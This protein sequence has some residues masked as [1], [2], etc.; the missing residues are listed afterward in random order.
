MET[1]AELACAWQSVK[2]IINVTGHSKFELYLED[3]DPGSPKLHAVEIFNQTTFN[4][5]LGILAF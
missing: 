5:N 4:K 2:E 1:I 3:I